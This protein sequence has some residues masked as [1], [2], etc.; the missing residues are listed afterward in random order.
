[1]KLG[2]PKDS[3]SY[4]QNLT[5]AF[6]D[7]KSYN[8]VNL[9]CQGNVQVK[10]NK[11]ALFFSS[12]MFQK[13]FETNC[14]CNNTSLLQE[15]NIL[16]PDF[17]PDAMAKV[18]EL[19]NSGTTKV[20][21]DNF[22][23]GTGMISIMQSLQISINQEP[24]T[25]DNI[26]MTSK[27]MTDVR[28]KLEKMHKNIDDFT[29]TIKK[30]SPKNSKGS[31]KFK[32]SSQ[33]LTEKCGKVPMTSQKKVKTTDEMEIAQSWDEEA[34]GM[35]IGKV[36]ELIETPE[37]LI[38]KPESS[39]NDEMN[40][41]INKHPMPYSCELCDLRLPT[42]I[43]LEQHLKEHMNKSKLH[44]SASLVEQKQQQQ[45][46]Q[47]MENDNIETIDLDDDDIQEVEEITSSLL[48][49]ICDKSF[50]NLLS[51]EVHL[52]THSFE[53][54]SNRDPLEITLSD[55]SDNELDLTDA[56]EIIWS[57]TSSKDLTSGTEH[58]SV[59]GGKN[60]SINCPVCKDDKPT[61]EHLLIHMATCHYKQQFSQLADKTER[62][63]KTCDTKFGTYSQL[64]SHLMSEKHQLM[65]RF[66]PKEIV[67]TLEEIKAGLDKKKADNEGKK[68]KRKRKM[69][70]DMDDSEEDEIEVLSD[71][72]SPKKSGGN[73][74][75]TNFDC[76]ICSCRETSMSH[77]NVHIGTVHC[78]EE[79]RRLVNKDTISC[80]LCQ[81]TFKVLQHVESHLL[82][83]HQ[84]LKF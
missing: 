51:Y 3:K 66:V 36:I 12:K 68:V 39:S 76:P 79:V 18:L 60:V 8:D 69:V 22:E 49:P 45:K 42:F 43:G 19:I 77:L 37:G 74:L 44:E 21:T 23:L 70:M 52:K 33:N 4:T 17:D 16:C 57:E 10:T 13:I 61:F 47:Q 84:L 30:T 54:T 27:K 31:K 59:R 9:H 62:K 7:Y 29:D 48:C 1:M 58:K 6:D 24:A 35:T 26:S 15:Y 20:S 75:N 2:N 34:F 11:I 40:E 53:N 38:E 55:T 80:N 64:I 28:D 81:K 46:Q 56:T 50:K 14:D 65:N 71:N 82:Q 32:V 25:G 5:K 67:E 63:C 73:R 83:R 41:I 78:R 72:E